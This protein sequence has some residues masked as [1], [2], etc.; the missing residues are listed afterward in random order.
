VIQ[1]ALP[2]WRFFDYQDEIE[3]WYSDLSEEG[4]DIFDAILKAN[5]KAESPTQWV[6]SKGL[7]G[8]RPKEH[9]IWEWYF[10]AD[11]RQERL[12]GIFG[13]NQK[14]AVF[15][16]GCS[17]KQNIYKPANCLETAVNR[18]KEVRKGTVNVYERTVK[19]DI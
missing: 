6:S 13:K 14:E 9:S 11:G 3:K 5:Q 2:R 4:Q 12:L 18:A 7:Q 8:G 10:R 15:L 19:Q 1:F 17:H 16:I